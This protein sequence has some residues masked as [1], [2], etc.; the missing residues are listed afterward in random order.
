V[1]ICGPMCIQCSFGHVFLEDL[2]NLRLALL[3]LGKNVRLGAVSS[4]G[5]SISMVWRSP[6]RRLPILV[7]FLIFMASSDSDLT[8]KR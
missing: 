8:V 3:V 1:R 5:T 2:S 6:E 4:T 7:A